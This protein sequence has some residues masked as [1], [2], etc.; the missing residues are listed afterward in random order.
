[1]NNTLK[2]GIIAIIVFAIILILTSM[3]KKKEGYSNMK[4]SNVNWTEEQKAFVKSKLDNMILCPDESKDNKISDCVLKKLCKYDPSIVLKEFEIGENSDLVQDV[5]ASCFVK[6]KCKLPSWIDEDKRKAI[7]LV[8]QS[9]MRDKT[10]T[11]P[12]AIA[13]RAVCQVDMAHK[14]MSYEDMVLFHQDGV[15]PRP[16]IANQLGMI[17]GACYTSVPCAGD[18]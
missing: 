16:K 12:D 1:M 2:Y 18:K 17:R 5:M 15:A 6:N 11:N 14:L 3:M 4:S 13:K 8:I 7:D 10:C 9:V